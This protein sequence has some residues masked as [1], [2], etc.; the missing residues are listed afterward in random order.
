MAIPFSIRDSRQLCPTNG[1][2]GFSAQSETWN[3]IGFLL[4]EQGTIFLFF[5]GYCPSGE[6]N[7]IRSDSLYPEHGS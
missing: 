7:F 2:P 5:G 6:D 3:K 4:A 1:Q